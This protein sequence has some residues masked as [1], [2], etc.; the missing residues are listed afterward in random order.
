MIAPNNAAISR[1]THAHLTGQCLVDG[2]CE[3]CAEE[4]DV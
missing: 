4:A 1:E 3:Q 2:D